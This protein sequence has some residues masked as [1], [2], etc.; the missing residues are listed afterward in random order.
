MELTGMSERF[1]GTEQEAKDVTQV[2]EDCRRSVM[3]AI[4][5]AWLSSLSGFRKSS[6][7]VST[8]SSSAAGSAP[9][10]LAVALGNRGQNEKGQCRAHVRSSETHQKRLV[11]SACSPSRLPTAWSYWR[12]VSGS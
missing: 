10:T 9:E 2:L 1:A 5:L 6:S 8:V 12:S 3:L 11:H 4:N 7:S